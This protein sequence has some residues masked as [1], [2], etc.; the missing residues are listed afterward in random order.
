MTTDPKDLE[1][2]RADRI[3]AEQ[4]AAEYARWL[5]SRPKDAPGQLGLFTGR[6]VKVRDS[7]LTLDFGKLG[8]DPNGVRRKH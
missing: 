8:S 7:Q 3:G 4:A 1:R 5:A 6:P 2:M